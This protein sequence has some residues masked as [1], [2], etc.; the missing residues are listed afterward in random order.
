MVVIWQA[1]IAGSN[2]SFQACFFL[3]F[4]KGGL[5]L[6]PAFEIPQLH[7]LLSPGKNL[8]ILFSLVH[9]GEDLTRNS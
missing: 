8:F 7:T 6:Q 1:F 5:L 3:L 4:A 2:R 9:A